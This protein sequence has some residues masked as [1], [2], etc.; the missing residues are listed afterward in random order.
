M[1]RVL[2]LP[3]F[4]A[5][6]WACSH[7]REA[8]QTKDSQ[9]SSDTVLL[10]SA[11]NRNLTWMD[12]IPAHNMD[13]D[14]RYV[15]ADR[16]L[17]MMVNLVNTY[18]MDL[19]RFEG[20]DRHESADSMIS[21]YSFHLNE[22]NTSC[23]CYSILVWKPDEHLKAQKWTWQ[24]HIQSIFEIDPDKGL[25]LLL[26]SEKL[27]GCEYLNTVQVIQ[28]HSDTLNVEYPAFEGKY[29][30]SIHNGAFTYDTR[31]KTLI[32]RDLLD[33]RGTL[34]FLKFNGIAFHSGN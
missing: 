22:F 29:R 2:L 3:L 15:T 31:E 5:L 20:L 25:Y 21:F 24:E 6:F 8:G 28:L 26:L 19:N 14:S 18:Q 1:K 32:I 33:D 13:K 34:G 7:T 23:S 17:D 12:E 9:S 11:I 27:S 10:I 30:L 4:I 16:T